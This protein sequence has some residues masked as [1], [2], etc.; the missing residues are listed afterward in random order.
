MDGNRVGWRRAQFQDFRCVS[1]DVFRRKPSWGASSWACILLWCAGLRI[2]IM[3]PIP[4][5]KTRTQKHTNFGTSLMDLQT[6]RKSRTPDKNGEEAF[7]GQELLHAATTMAMCV[8]TGLGK[9]IEQVQAR[10]QRH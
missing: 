6:R 10:H 8:H 4:L 9:G 2:E 1:G 3:T 7:S 5:Q